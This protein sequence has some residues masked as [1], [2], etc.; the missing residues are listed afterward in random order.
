MHERGHHPKEPKHERL[1][2]LTCFWS[3]SQIEMQFWHFGAGVIFSPEVSC[4]V[5]TQITIFF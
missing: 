2:G 1:S 3:Q 5:L 4:L